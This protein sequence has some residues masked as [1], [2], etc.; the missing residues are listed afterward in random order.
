MKNLKALEK[1]LGELN[2]FNLPNDWLSR[3]K[4]GFTYDGFKEKTEA[5]TVFAD[6][7]VFLMLEC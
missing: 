7:P 3:L 6:F 2:L 5:K 1:S 4:S